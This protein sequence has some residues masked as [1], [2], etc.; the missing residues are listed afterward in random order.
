MPSI[1][2]KHFQNT[3]LNLYYLARSVVPAT[4]C[5]T[6]LLRTLPCLGIIPVFIVFLVLNLLLV[7][8]SIPQ[9]PL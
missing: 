5:I 1:A 4:T 6:V 9:Y 7:R 2:S 3:L 8:I